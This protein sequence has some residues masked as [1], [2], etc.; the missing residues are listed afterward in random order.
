M[1]IAFG[2]MPSQTFIFLISIKSDCRKRFLHILY[3]NLFCFRWGKYQSHQQSNRSPPV[4]S[5]HEVR[6]ASVDTAPLLF[7]HHHIS[8]LG[9]SQGPDRT[10][11]ICFEYIAERNHTAG[12]QSHHMLLFERPPARSER[13]RRYQLPIKEDT[14]STG[15]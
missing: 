13:Q 11:T 4:I 9:L 14:R 5:S 2:R 15:R 1:G 3:H 10:D 12:I 7:R 6:P 8:L